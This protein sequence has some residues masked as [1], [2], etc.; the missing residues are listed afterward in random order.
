MTSV[1]L[2]G[3][4]VRC[5]VRFRDA[6]QVVFDPVTVLVT[7]TDPA[8]NQALHTYGAGSTIRRR[9]TGRYFIDVPVDTPGR[10]S[11]YWRCEDGGRGA[12]EKDFIVRAARG[13]PPVP[14][15]GP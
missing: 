10:W 2:V 15:P 8:G 5:H 11:Y 7:V 3:G 4:A 13:A 12:A 1:Y 14:P 9:G 6:E